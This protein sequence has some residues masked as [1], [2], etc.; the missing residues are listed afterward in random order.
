MNKTCI[1]KSYF[2][3]VLYMTIYRRKISFVIGIK[4][5]RKNYKNNLTKRKTDVIVLNVGTRD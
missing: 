3:V 2:F 5:T 4:K 1:Y